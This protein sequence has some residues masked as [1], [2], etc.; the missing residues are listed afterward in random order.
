MGEARPILPEDT[1]DTRAA[2]TSRMATI[3]IAQAVAATRPRTPTSANTQRLSA[4]SLWGESGQSAPMEVIN[5]H[6]LH[7]IKP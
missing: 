6:K 2:T 5:V 7:G 3:P 1:K 4:H